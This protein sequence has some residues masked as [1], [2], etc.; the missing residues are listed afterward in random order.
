MKIVYTNMYFG[1]HNGNW[2]T[3]CYDFSKQWAEDEN[4]VHVITARYYKSDLFQKSK[5]LYTYEI[6]DGIHV[7]IVNVEI[8]NMIRVL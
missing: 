8:N 1:T 7:H 2:S 4:E 6:I 3:R 5:G